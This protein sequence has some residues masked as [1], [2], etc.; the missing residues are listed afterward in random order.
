MRFGCPRRYS[1]RE[2][3]Q[4]GFTL[5]ELTIAMTFVALVATG[6][7]VSISTCLKVWRSSLQAADL[8]QEARAVMQMLSRDIRGAHLGLARDAGYFRGTPAGNSGGSSDTLELC[9]ESSAPSRVALLPEEMRG[10]WDQA[11]RPPLSDYVGVRYEERPA[12]GDEPAGLYRIAYVVPGADPDL[13]D[14]LGLEATRTELVSTTVVALRFRYLDGEEWAGSW[15]TNP[16]DTRLPRA[17]AIELTLRDER[18][19]DHAY[20]TI[21]PIATR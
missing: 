19:R 14:E 9:T 4:R 21:V 7:A 8:N 17:V 12:E 13:P 16:E 6:I 15:E 5:L 11:A 1:E 18:E 2:R 10:E 3:G 20:Q